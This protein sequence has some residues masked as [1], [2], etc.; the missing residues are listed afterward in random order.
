MAERRESID[1]LTEKI[2][3]LINDGTARSICGHNGTF[4]SF[5]AKTGV[6]RDALREAVGGPDSRGEVGDHKLSP[7][8]ARKIETAFGF[9]SSLQKE[10]KTCSLTRYQELFRASARDLEGATDDD[11]PK[12]QVM[13]A[14]RRIWCC[15]KEL[16]TLELQVSQPGPGEPWPISFELVCNPAYIMGVTVAVRSGLLDLRLGGGVTDK[17]GVAGLH[18][19]E[20]ASAPPVSLRQSGFSHNPVW[21]IWVDEG[22]IG[23]LSSVPHDFCPV[24]DLQAGAVIEARF[25]VYVM[26]LENVI[27]DHGTASDGEFAVDS[28]D[29]TWIKSATLSVNKLRVLKRMAANSLP[30]GEQGRA[31]IAYDELRFEDATARTRGE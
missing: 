9:S 18:V 6:K 4:N 11:S 3:F 26:Y 12:L 21:R 20:R 14:G 28:E 8:N 1:A 13:R 30:G 15:D 31:V 10:W 16:A 27:D 7:T 24:H 17:G 22:P 25:Q 19:L 29:L 5:V 23:L 2:W